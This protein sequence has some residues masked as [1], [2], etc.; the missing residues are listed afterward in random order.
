MTV[1]LTLESPLRTDQYGTVRVGGTRVTLDSVIG[2]YKRGDSPEEIA[3]GFP[4]LALA[5][6]YA[7]I[8][9]YLSH[10]GEADAYLSKGR[11]EGDEAL[12]RLEELRPA[13]EL[14]TRL[15]RA[16]ATSIDPE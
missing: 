9:Y 8:A 14:R 2:A 1:A 11:D 3:E 7:A 4:A 13:T 12:Q 15:R 5:D 6:V 10:Q 16:R